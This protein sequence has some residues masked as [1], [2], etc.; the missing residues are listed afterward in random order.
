MTK[1][2]SECGEKLNDENASF[3]PQCG[4][5]VNEDTKVEKNNKPLI[6]GLVAIVVVLIIAIGFVTGGFALFGESTSILLISESPVS[7]S[8]NFTVELVSG[9]QGVSGKDIQITF[10]NSTNSY[11]FTAIT[12]NSGLANV[13]PN[14]GAGEY[15]VEVKFTGDDKYSKSSTSGKFNVETKITEIDSQ[16]TSTRTEPDYES[17]SYTHSFEDTDK[18][19][20]G[21]VYLSD[22]N[23]AHTPKNIVKQMFA[24]SDSN[25]DGRLNHDEYYKFMYK[26]NYDKSSYGL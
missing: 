8:G 18:N 13:I 6:L 5:R 11:D 14:V 4:E 3:C 1:Y 20:D 16:V 15:D 12:D 22:M 10:K 24:D 17:F 19:G 21:Y 2:C 9:N 23:I 26:L 25:G 7:N